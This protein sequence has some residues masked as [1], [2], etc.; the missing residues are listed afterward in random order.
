VDAASAS[1]SATG[2]DGDDIR[3]IARV[4]TYRI[5]SVDIRVGP[6]FPASATSMGRVLLAGLTP[7]PSADFGCG[8]SCCVP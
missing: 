6:L 7:S 2:L 4:N 3:Y 1:A 5:M 8:V